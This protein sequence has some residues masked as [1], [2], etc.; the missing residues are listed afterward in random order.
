MYQPPTCATRLRLVIADNNK[1]DKGA[2]ENIEGVKGVLKL[3]ASFRSS[4]EQEL[5]IKYLTSLS[6]LQALLPVRKQRPRQLPP[7]SR[8]YL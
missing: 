4:W 7:N 6:P 2:L 3:P 1:A 8:M 5:S